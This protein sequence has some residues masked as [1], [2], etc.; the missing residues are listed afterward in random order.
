MAV[1]GYIGC[2]TVK[3]PS[4]RHLGNLPAQTTSFGGR[5][6][7]LTEVKIRLSSA[8]LVSLVGPGG[9]GKTRLAIRA[10]TDLGRAFRGGVW[11]VALAEVREPGLLA[12]AVLAALD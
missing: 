12:D 4:Y 1:R 7:E 6:V 9:V 5:R 8:C 2:R 11:L 10:A 3:T